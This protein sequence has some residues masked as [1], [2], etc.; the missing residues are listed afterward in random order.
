VL[1]PARG[2]EEEAASGRRIRQQRQEASAPRNQLQPRPRFLHDGRAGE[3]SQHSFAGSFQF[4][5]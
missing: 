4:R 2:G 1:R 3:V 5:L